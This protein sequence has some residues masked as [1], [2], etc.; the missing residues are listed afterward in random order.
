M[1]RSD[2]R[3]SVREAITAAERRAYRIELDELLALSKR[4]V[5]VDTKAVLATFAALRAQFV[6]LINGLGD[7]PTRVAYS[8][9]LV[10]L[11]AAVAA[12]GVRL[13]VSFAEMQAAHFDLGA[14]IVTTPLTAAGI[15]GLVY[16]VATEDITLLTF[17]RAG[18]VGGVSDEIRKR[19]GFEIAGIASGTATPLEAVRRIGANLTSPNHFRSI[20]ARAQAIMVTELGRA[21]SMGG[22]RSMEDHAETL[23]DLLKRWLHAHVGQARENHLALESRHRVGGSIG[24]IPVA[25][26]YIVAGIPALYPRAASLPAKE[27]V[28]CRCQSIPV[29]AEM[30]EEQPT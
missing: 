22:Q 13:D 18:L 7:T 1:A 10:E 11:D 27:T 28:H 20:A 12:W 25:E 15:E 29:L 9:A 14:R 21:N 23:P 26:S 5:G 16:G 2:Q 24:P 17:F 19:I 6:A 30:L 3:L 8:R 4:T